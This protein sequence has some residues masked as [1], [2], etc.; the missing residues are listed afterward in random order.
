METTHS[1]ISDPVDADS[2]PIVHEPAVNQY[3]PNQK[4]GPGEVVVLDDDGEY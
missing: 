2:S 4:L 1:E 3:S